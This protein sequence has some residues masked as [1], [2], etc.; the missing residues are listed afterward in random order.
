MNTITVYVSSANTNKLRVLES[1]SPHDFPPLT[2]VEI[3]LDSGISLTS[4]DYPAEIVAE[5]S[6][7]GVVTLALGLIPGVFTTR[8]YT[9]A[10]LTTEPPITV[11]YYWGMFRIRAIE[12]PS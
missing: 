10:L 12:E 2:K 5:T 4:D 8:V 3:R 6:P 9:A 11:P 7:E 1:G